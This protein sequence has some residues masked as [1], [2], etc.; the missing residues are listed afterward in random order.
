MKLLDYY[1]EAQVKRARRAHLLEQT[2]QLFRTR[3]PECCTMAEI[4]AWC[5]IERKTLYRYYHSKLSLIVDTYL[6]VVENEL[7][8]QQ[9]S[10]NE[11]RMDDYTQAIVQYLKR[12]KIYLIDLY[13]REPFVAQFDLFYMQTKNDETVRFRYESISTRIASESNSLER[14]LQAGVSSGEITRGEITVH[15]L[16]TIIDQSLRAYVTKTFLR[17]DETARYHD[18]R[19]DDWIELLVRGLAQPREGGHTYGSNC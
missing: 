8:Q 12:Q 6:F 2:V 7:L 19:I 9:T 5:N 15:R 14:L 11:T 1:N 13:T 4:A 17:D 16:A 10:R 3:A 18:E